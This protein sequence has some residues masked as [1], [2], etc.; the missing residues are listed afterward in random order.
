MALPPA[1]QTVIKW[2]VP[3]GVPEERKEMEM[4]EKDA[5]R[6]KIR[7]GQLVGAAQQ[8]IEKYPSFDAEDRERFDL[9]FDAVN[10]AAQALAQAANLI[11][12]L[13]DNLQAGQA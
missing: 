5:I 4:D 11:A 3:G 2:G 8:A 6:I 7:I 1:G 13:R 9:E 12:E 10:D